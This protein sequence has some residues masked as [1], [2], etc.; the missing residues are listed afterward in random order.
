VL[1]NYFPR[2]ELEQIRY[3]GWEQSQKINSLSI[4]VF[5]DLFC[6]MVYHTATYN[7][8]AFFIRERLVQ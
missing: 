6:G 4:S 2:A 1:G 3:R 5:D 8:L 7:Q